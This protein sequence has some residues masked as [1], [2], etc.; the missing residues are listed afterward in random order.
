MEALKERGLMQKNAPHLVGNQPF[1]VP[2]YD[3]WEG[4]FYG[5]GMKVYDMLA[6]KQG[7]GRSKWLSVE[8]TTKE[9]PTL[10]T[11]GLKGGVV[12]YDG[13]FDDSRLAINMAQTA[14]DQGGTVI[15]YM[16][17]TDLTRSDED[18]ING[19][20]ATDME[21][22]EE[23][24][25][26]SK[27]VVNATGPWTDEIRKM[28][29]PEASRRIMPSQGVHIVLDSSFLPGDSAIMVPRTEDG[30]VLFAIPWHGKAVVGTTDTEIPDTPMEPKPKEEE[31]KFLIEHAAKYMN[32]DPDRSDVLS[33][34]VGIRPL[35]APE[36]AD[37][38]SSV[39]R[40]H[41]LTISHAG[42]V[43]IAGGKWTTY[44]K[45]A[46]DT[47]DQAATLAG[48]DDRPC[49]TKELHIH[50]YHQNAKQFGDLEFYGADAAAIRDL[51]REKDSYGNQLN[52]ALPTKEVEV[53]WAARNEMA[54]TVEDFLS[55]RTRSLLLDAR[56]SVEM[57]PKVAEILANE[58]GKDDN[59]KEEQLKEYNDLADQYILS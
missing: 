3:W 28:E 7:F 5:V 23:Y 10:E 31:V 59:W 38:T 14:V 18:L 41:S 58:L 19:V 36:D 12:Y 6:G 27:V 47:V 53:V 4:P 56:A 50:G 48:L 16:N 8:E 39:S 43:T 45:M 24:E 29:D 34:F 51:M 2:N 20:I 33:M 35:V 17:V 15:N 11:E 52:D 30:R 37:D 40:D 32:K 57:A 54:R 22:G 55:R 1:I 46:E 21:T 26:T 44:R 42:L 13:Q 49:V 25:L 9:I